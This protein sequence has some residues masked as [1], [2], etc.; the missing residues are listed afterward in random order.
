MVFLVYQ[1]VEVF[2]DVVEWFRPCY[3]FGS[4]VVLLQIAGLCSNRFVMV[5]GEALTV[6]VFDVT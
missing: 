3:G 5:F 2:D 6:Q 4:P 1:M